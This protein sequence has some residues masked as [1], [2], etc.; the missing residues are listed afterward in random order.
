MESL[1]NI[2]DELTQS[3]EDSEELL[4]HNTN[5][6][7]D[8]CLNCVYEKHSTYYSKHRCASCSHFY[9][10]YHSRRIMTTEEIEKLKNTVECNKSILE[11]VK[12]WQ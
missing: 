12:K 6:A 7:P 2:I 1:K 4:K 10:D 9:Q 11:N 3:L 5:N 8:S